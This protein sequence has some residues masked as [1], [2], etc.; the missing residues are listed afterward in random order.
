MSSFTHSIAV[1]FARSIAIAA[2]MGSTMLAS[3]PT[4][5]RAETSLPR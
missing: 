2:L 5:A 4:A 1:P 3:P